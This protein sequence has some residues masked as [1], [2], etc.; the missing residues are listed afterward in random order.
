MEIVGRLSKRHAYLIVALLFAILFS[1]IK[2]PSI[3]FMACLGCIIYMYKWYKEGMRD[4]T[5][6]HL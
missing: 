3:S 2:L 5:N 1:T 4:Y 6:G